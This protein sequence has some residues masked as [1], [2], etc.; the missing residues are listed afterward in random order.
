MFRATLTSLL[1]LSYHCGDWV[2][3]PKRAKRVVRLAFNRL[4]LWFP[5]GTLFSVG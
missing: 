1:I 3:R 2:D 4:L 5:G